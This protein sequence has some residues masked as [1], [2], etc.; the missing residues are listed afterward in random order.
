MNDKYWI[1]VC[2]A[3]KFPKNKGYEK[4][5]N[6]DFSNPI[7]RKQIRNARDNE[8]DFYMDHKI[9]FDHLISIT[10]NVILD[11]RCPKSTCVFCLMHDSLIYDFNNRSSHSY[12]LKKKCPHKN[13]DLKLFTNQYKFFMKQQALDEDAEYIKEEQEEKKRLELKKKKDEAEEIK[14]KEDDFK[15]RAD[16][17]NNP[18]PRSQESILREKHYKKCKKELEIEN[19]MI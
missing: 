2:C 13:E 17:Y 8:T 5:Q 15:S 6:L 14:R 9:W 16:F 11:A 7:V 1:S 3:K 10:E 12:H 4:L 18:P 19:I